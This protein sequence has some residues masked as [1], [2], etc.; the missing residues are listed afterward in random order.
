V[1][2]K[3]DSKP[4]ST[5]DYVDRAQVGPREEGYRSS[6]EKPCGCW[7][8]DDTEDCWRSWCQS[9]SFALDGLTHKHD[10]VLDE[11]HLLILRK[12][13]ELDDF[14]REFGVIVPWGP[15]GHP[16][17]YADR[18]IAWENVAARYDGLIITPYIWERRMSDEYR[19]YYTWDCASGCIWNV[20]AIKEIRLLEINEKIAA[21][22]EAA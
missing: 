4:I 20:R 9:E 18:C 22:Q 21:K 8:T 1:W 15:P 11:S 7:I 19:W 14:T 5:A 12:P 6:Y 3:Y 10:V 16:N 17:K 2:L 13:W